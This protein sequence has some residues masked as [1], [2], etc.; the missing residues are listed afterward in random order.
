MESINSRNFS[1]Y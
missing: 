1:K